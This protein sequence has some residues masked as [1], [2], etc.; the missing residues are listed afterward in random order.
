MTTVRTDVTIEAKKK[1]CLGRNTV[2]EW[3]RENAEKDKARKNLLQPQKPRGHCQTRIA[4]TEKPLE[5]VSQ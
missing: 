4:K 3:T 5:K 2:D 1:E